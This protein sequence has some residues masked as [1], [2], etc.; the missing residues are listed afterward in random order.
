MQDLR[1]ALRLDLR[2]QAADA[3]LDDVRVRVEVVVPNA[4]HDCRLGNDASLIAHEIFE[5]LIFKP[6]EFDAPPGACDAVRDEVL[7]QVVDV[8]DG[9]LRRRLS[10]ADLRVDA[11]GQ[12][13]NG[14]RLGEIVVRTSL[15]PEDF[16]LNAAARTE[17]DDG[18]LDARRAE[19]AHGLHAV[20]ARHHHVHDDRVESARLRGGECLL[21]V[22]RAERH[23]ALAPEAVRHELGD[24]VIVLGYQDVHSPYPIRNP[25]RS[26]AFRW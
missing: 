12:F 2:A 10:A 11:R 15:Q 18:R 19:S 14:E 21:A 9:R 4:I 16:R 3:A 25:I 17:D 20:E 6:L 13:G 26:L 22:A 23:V 7:L 24:L 5:Q 1:L 8:Q